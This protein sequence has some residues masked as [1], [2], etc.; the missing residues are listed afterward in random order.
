M[1]RNEHPDEDQT[2]QPGNA[3]SQVAEAAGLTEGELRAIR[4]DTGDHF[5][6]GHEGVVKVWEASV[7]G[8]TWLA[9]EK[10]REAEIKAENEK[11][12]ASQKDDEERRKTL[13]KALD[14]AR[15]ASKK[16]VQKQDK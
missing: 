14:K 15:A 7:D 1:A 5:S 2:P 3:E 16:A 12:E 8:Q 4:S 9:G 6:A 11:V 13:E 10:E